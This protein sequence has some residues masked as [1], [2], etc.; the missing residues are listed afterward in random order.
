MSNRCRS[1]SNN[2]RGHKRIKKRIE[3]REEGRV[4]ARKDKGWKIEGEK[5]QVT[6]EEYKRLKEDF[7][8]SSMMA[9][10]RLWTHMDKKIREERGA[11]LPKSA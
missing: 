9:Q 5:K 10:K 8:D 4:P 3:V 1:E 11:L 7:Q 6:R 2:D